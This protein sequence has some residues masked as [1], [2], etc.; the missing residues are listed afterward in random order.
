MKK[1]FMVA[2]LTL[3]WSGAAF[4]GPCSSGLLS[5]LIG[6]SCT[7]GKLQ[8]SNFTYTDTATGTANAIPASGI[9]VAPVIENGMFGLQ[10]VGG[11]SVSQGNGQDSVIGFTVTALSGSINSMSLDM[12]GVGFSND[13]LATVAENTSTG[14]NLYVFDGPSGT[15]LSDPLALSPVTSFTVSKDINVNGG[16]S[17]TTSISMVDNLYSDTPEPASLALFGSG[18]LG[19]A[20]L[21]RRFG[22]RA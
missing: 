7:V 20:G 21:V 11:W 22:C 3:A 8:F 6:N 16:L 17:G 1:L 14:Q 2:M 12:G 15:L 10:F 5:K 9:S 4:A 19:L 18:L 13:G